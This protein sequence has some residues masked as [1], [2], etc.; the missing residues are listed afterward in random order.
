VGIWNRARSRIRALVGGGTWVSPGH[1][2]SPIPSP[3]DLTPA[4][5]SPSPPGLPGLDLRVDRQLEVLRALD[6]LQADQGYRGPAPHGEWRYR[7]DNDMFGPGSASMLHLMLRHLRP[8]RV[9]EVGSGFSSAVM[10]DT[11]E[12]WLGGKTDFTFIDP[13]PRRLHSLLKPVDR[14]R[15]RILAQ[16][17]QEVGPEAFAALEA[18]DVVFVD[19]S[20]VLKT[21]GDVCHILFRI[22]PA[23]R[24]GV[25][26]HVHDVLYPFEYPRPWV[27]EGRAWNEA[28]ALRAFLLYNASFGILI[29]ASYLYQH[30]RTEL[31]RV[32]SICAN[33]SSLWIERQ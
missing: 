23:L 14:T 27:E 20:H 8:R 16:R 19:S 2:Y 18:N 3:G 30:Q 24:S 5:W 15:V 1:Y 7:S 29:W 11:D 17:V 9:I 33:G 6:L 13:D 21:G 32:E 10:L 12:H 26:V 25:V 31:S 4:L 28:Y 22:L